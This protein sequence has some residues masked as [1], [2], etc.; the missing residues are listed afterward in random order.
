MPMLRRDDHGDRIDAAGQRPLAGNIV[1]LFHPANRLAAE[2]VL[3]A[4]RPA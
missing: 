1:E 2:G 4:V 3:D